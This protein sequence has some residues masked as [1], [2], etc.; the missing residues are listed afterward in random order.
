MNGYLTLGSTVVADVRFVGVHGLPG[1]GFFKLLI[2]LGVTGRAQALLAKIVLTSLSGE[3]WIRASGGSDL[4]VGTLRLS[5]ERALAS[6]FQQSGEWPLYLEAELSR[7]RIEAIEDVR[8]GGDLNLKLN[9]RGLVA[10]GGAIRQDSVFSDLYYMANQSAWV[11]TLE[12]MGYRETLLLEMPMPGEN[13]LPRM[14]QAVEHLRNAQNMLMTGRY[15]EA[16]GACRDVL[17]SLDASL[18]DANANLP[19]DQR[20]WTKAQRVVHARRG[21]KALTHP[22]RHADEVAARIEY[23]SLDA[24]AVLAMTAALVRLA[25]A[26]ADW[27]GS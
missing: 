6:L 14:G 21:L 18:G 15:R 22:A 7:R 9:L 12:R 16:V 11:A 4:L 19:S 13:G 24:K 5:D 25:L 2:Q 23:D 8:L 3:L 20:T 17:E 10:D 1:L 27:R 26:D